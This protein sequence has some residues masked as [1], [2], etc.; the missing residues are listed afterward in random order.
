MVQSRGDAG[1]G[2]T[3]FRYIDPDRFEEASVPYV[4]GPG[5]GGEQL[6]I[7]DPERRRIESELMAEDGVHGVDIGQT[8][9]GDA[10]IVVYVHDEAAKQRL[11]AR[12]SAWRAPL[13][14]KVTGPI[15][16]Q[17]G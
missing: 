11:S 14:F 13:V 16:A 3:G 4:P 15:D 2:A 9:T 6:P 5:G 12:Q 1:G 8:P 17:P 7:P 10:A